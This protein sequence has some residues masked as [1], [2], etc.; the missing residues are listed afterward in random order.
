MRKKTPSIVAGTYLAGV[1]GYLIFLN[2]SHNTVARDPGIHGWKE[3]GS[4]TIT[5]S[6]DTARG[7]TLDKFG[8]ATLG[9]SS[10]PPSD[11]RA[12]K[13][14]SWR[15]DDDLK[16][17]LVTFDAVEVDYLLASAPGIETCILVK[18]DLSAADLTQSWFSTPEE[19]DPRDEPPRF[20]R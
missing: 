18:G 19:G 10:L 3:L 4:C 12:V 9:D 6:L 20:D 11:K 14:G 16:R 2:W 1:A 17:Y 5:I 13:R 8:V 15:Y 7:L